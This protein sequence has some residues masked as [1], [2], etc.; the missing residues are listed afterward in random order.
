MK[1]SSGKRRKNEAGEGSS[2]MLLPPQVLPVYIHIYTYMCMYIYVD[3]YVNM[4][5]KN[6]N[7][8]N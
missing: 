1:I 2:A 5:G 3:T 8:Q 6:W 7:E 4:G